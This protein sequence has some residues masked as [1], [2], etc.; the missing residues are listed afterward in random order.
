MYDSEGTL[1]WHGRVIPGNEGTITNLH[2]A[3]DR[4][5]EEVVTMERLQHKGFHVWRLYF[6]CTLY[7]VSGASG[8]QACL[9]CLVTFD[10]L[11]S[12]CG[13]RAAFVK[14]TLESMHTFH[15]LRSA[16][17][18]CNIYG[19]LYSL[20][21]EECHLMDL[22]LALQ[23]SPNMELTTASDDTYVAAVKDL[24]TY[25]EQLE[26]ICL[27]HPLLSSLVEENERCSNKIAELSLQD[28]HI[29]THTM[30]IPN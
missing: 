4:C 1:T 19:Q 27:E 30:H 2:I 12:G 15:S 3:L 8:K 26:A 20:L 18:D 7:R 25:K 22:K 29:H 28:Q 11:E 6:L 13:L 9:F 21:E 17:L 5:K 16:F 14:R 23:M 24:T 10:D